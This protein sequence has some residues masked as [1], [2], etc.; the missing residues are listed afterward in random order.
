MSFCGGDFCADEHKADEFA[1]KLKD[2]VGFYVN[3]GGRSST[4][5]Q[6]SAGGG[7]SLC[8]TAGQTCHENAS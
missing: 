5:A 6:F 3:G 1:E 4:S 8:A 2:V 7:A